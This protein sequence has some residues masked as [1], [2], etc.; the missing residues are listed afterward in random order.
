M[1]KNIYFFLIFFVFLLTFGK[2][3]AENLNISFVDMDK[4]I[5]ESIAGKKIQK[6]FNKTIEKENEK[7]KKMEDDLKKKEE[8]ILK[9][10]NIISKEELD[11]KIKDFQDNLNELRSNRTKFNR[12]IN[13]KNLE[14]TNKMVNEINKILIKYA[15]DNSI[16]FVIQKKN[17]IIGKSEFDITDKILE[18]FNDQI[19]SI[20]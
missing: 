10:K 9:Q 8:E 18:Q 7:F 17:I 5:S 4:I 20:E 15:A 6:S 19:K 1:K 16:S 2:L 11:K 3:N 12:E 13:K 14:A